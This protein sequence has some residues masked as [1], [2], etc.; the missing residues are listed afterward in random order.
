MHCCLQEPC[1]SGEIIEVTRGFSLARK[2][3]R[4]RC[5]SLRAH[6]HYILAAWW[7][8]DLS[9]TLFKAWDA[10]GAGVVDC[11]ARTGSVKLARYPKSHAFA[12]LQGSDNILAFTTQRYSAQPLIV[13]YVLPGPGLDASVRSGCICPGAVRFEMKTLLPSLH[14]SLHVSIACP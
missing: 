9:K 2:W 3:A 10:L 8:N 4:G 5:S 6:N 1:V 13:R 14:A 11:K 7:S 12:Q